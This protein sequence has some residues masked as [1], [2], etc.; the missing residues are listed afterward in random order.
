MK[1]YFAEFAGTF[2]LVF[3]GVWSI[4]YSNQNLADNFQASLCLITIIFGIAV[5]SAIILFGEISGAHI[6]PAVSIAFFLNKSLNGVELLFYIIFQCLGAILGAYFFNLI[7]PSEYVGTTLPNVNTTFA[8]SF[9]M[10]LSFILMMVIFWIANPNNKHTKLAPYVIGLQVAIH[11]YIVG[12]ATSVSMNPARSIGPAL[13]SGH[14]EHYWIYL[15]APIVGMVLSF[16]VWKNF[17]KM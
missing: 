2:L 13:V 16:F 10:V 1:K 3:M 6:N 4:E 7:Y 12:L 9:E 11:T 17:K 14:W 15:I 8:F 5:T